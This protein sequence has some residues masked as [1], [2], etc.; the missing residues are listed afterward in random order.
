[1]TTLHFPDLVAPSAA[2][3]LRLAVALALSALLHAAVLYHTYG[4]GRAGAP[5]AGRY[6]ALSARLV[7]TELPPPPASALAAAVL[8]AVPDPAAPAPPAESTSRSASAIAPATPGPRGPALISGLRYY[9]GSELDRRATPLQAIEPDYPDDASGREHTVVL[10]VFINASGAVDNVAV[11]DAGPAEAFENA[12]RTAFARA[13][14]APGL[15][16]GVPV[17][18]QLV[19]EVKF[20]PGIA[21]AR[22]GEITATAPERAN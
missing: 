19:V 13:R 7:S 1:M 4:T 22:S 12:A 20:D 5:S 3:R 10:R 14:F 11:Q 17:K 15:L 21:G 18:S 16:R 9:L 2:V 8:A 6:D